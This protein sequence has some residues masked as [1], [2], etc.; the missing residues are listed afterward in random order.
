ML[1][2]INFTTSKYR[3]VLPVV[4]T[5]LLLVIYFIGT[6]IDKKNMVQEARINAAASFEKDIV[7]R[8][9]NAE[10]GSVYVPVT[11]KTP[12][13]P[14]LD[15]PHKE[16]VTED[17]TA[18]T[19]I[20]PAYM[21]RQVHELARE[22]YGI[23][24]HITS[25]NPIRPQNAPDSWEAAALNLFQQGIQEVYSEEIMEGKPYL[26]FMRPLTTE[27][28]CLKCHEK[29][30]YREGDVRGGISI[31][32]PLEPYFTIHS[33]RVKFSVW[34]IAFIWIA[35][36]GSFFYGTNSINKL[37]KIKEEVEEKRKLVEEK[38]IQKHYYLEKAMELGQIGTWEFDLLDNRL[39]WADENCR[40]FGL[41]E[42]SVVDYELFIER[43]HPDD[44]EYVYQKWKAGIE[45]KPFNIVHRL[46]VDGNIKWVREKAYIE[47]DEGGKAIKA[48][49]FTQDITVPK[50]TEEALKE[51]EERYKEFVEGTND[52]IIR[53]DK[54][55]KLT[56][57]NHISTKVFGLS[58]QD[59]IDMS[60]FDFIHP[61]DRKPTRDWIEDL[62]AS[63]KLYGTIENRQ[64]SQKGGVR[65]LFWNFSFHYD[66]NGNLTGINGIAR[67][68]TERKQ[69]ETQI[70]Q[71]KKM[72]GIGILAEGITH[73]FNNILSPI[74]LHSE[75]AMDDLTPDNPLQH[76]IKEI[77]KAGKRGRDL[78]RKISTFAGNGPEEK[79]LLKASLIVKEAINI[80]RATIPTTI[81]IQYSN[82]AENDTVLADPTHLNQI[83]MDLCTNAAHAM[84]EKGGVLEIILDNED[85]SG[86]TVNSLFNLKPGQYLKL[87]VRDTGPG[88]SQ[89]ILS[90][91]FEPY[92]TTKQHGEGTGLG[93]AIIHGIVQHYGGSITVESGVGPGTTFHVCLPVI[94]TETSD[95]DEHKKVISR[96]IER[97]LYVDDEKSS[98]DAMEMMFE[99][100]GYKVIVKTSSI[101]AFEAFR[102]D[103][104]EFDLAILDMIMPDM[105][106]KEL[107]GKLKSLRP[108][109]PIILCTEFAGQIDEK[110]ADKIGINALIL[111]PIIRSEIA[112]TIREVLDEKQLK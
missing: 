87:S 72:E 80:L 92:Y 44:R 15:A 55:I 94:D 50:Q 40:I 13:N 31:S 38:L 56:Y 77:Y 107:A 109:I 85:I 42:G 23:R 108:D 68:I 78:V 102:N 86:E 28:E 12:P 26:R 103:Q 64:V 11:E 90:R 54:D 29:Q 98:A 36:I 37:N 51:S 25:L 75:M 81:E 53:V 91:I 4:W 5:G 30:G 101:D 104:E 84:R 45:G 96:G 16:V 6:Y 63:Q 71:S 88:I 10:Y 2:I 47:F 52:L 17:G 46:L 100:L 9:W 70:L 57:A 48:I 1:K 61:D 14:F 24:G 112:E 32:V 74:M 76:N 7:F 22:Y 95:T 3:V 93:L 97:I 21:I 43:V 89:D 18:L 27:K 8:H 106:G 35:G 60:A 110:T 99:R 62:V 66:N 67:D 83:V 82:K 105:S 79:I 65:R 49:G 111:K 41:P 58:P 34:M 19:L 33:D 69:M 39:Y 73:D 59:C 20:N